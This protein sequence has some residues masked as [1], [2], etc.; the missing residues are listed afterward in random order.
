MSVTVSTFLKMKAEGK[1]ISMITAYDYTTARLVDESGIDSI[2]V[3][4]SLGN[5]ML[6]LGDTVSVT[7]EDMIHHGAAVAR[8]TKN[9]LVVVDMPFMSYQSSVHDAVV[10][11]GRLM[12]E[13]RANAVK[14]EG[15]VEVADRIRAIVDCRIPVCAHIG[16]TPQGINALGG[17]KVQGKTADSARKL[18]EDAHAVEEAGAFAVVL[19]AIPAELAERVSAE[20]TIP[21]IGIGAG[22]GCDGQV[23]VNQDMLGM[24]HDFT[25]KFV[26]RFAEVGDVMLEAYRAYDAAVKDGSFPAAEHT[27][28]APAGVLETL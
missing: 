2:L 9:A 28:A 15:G 16:L 18:L 21:T 10:N 3:G 25:P 14:L 13:A 22:A 1:K 27:Y 5:V 20:L 12:K 8:G 17:F 4:D 11:A 24:F 7:M 26:R 6:G 19:E 23:L